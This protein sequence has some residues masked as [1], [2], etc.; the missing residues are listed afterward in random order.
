FP[1]SI[2]ASIFGVK[3]RAYFEVPKEN[4]AVPQVQF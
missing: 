4:Q 1:S 3:E 2:I